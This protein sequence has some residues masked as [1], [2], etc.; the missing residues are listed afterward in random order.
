MNFYF[1]D[2]SGNNRRKLTD[3]E[4]HQHLSECQIE[5]AIEAKKEEPYEEVSYMTVGG[6]IVCDY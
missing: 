4:L 3:D 6:F 2:K 5:E 1:V